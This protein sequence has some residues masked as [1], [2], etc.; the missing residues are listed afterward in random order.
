MVSSRTDAAPPRRQDAT[1]NRRRI[2]DVA[3]RLLA[4]DPHA[5]MDDL[6]AAAGL[7]RR[8]VYGHFRRRE[9]L[10]QEVAR[11]AAAGIHAILTESIAEDAT[12]PAALAAFTA[13]LW[14][15]ADE[16]R[17]LLAA[18]RLNLGPGAVQD[19]LDPVDATVRGIVAAG[20]ASGHFATDVPA[21][22]LARVLRDQAISLL[23]SINDGLWDGDA[24]AAVRLMLRTLGVPEEKLP[25]ADG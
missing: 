4:R 5:N 3:R 24:D 14:N 20:Q 10:V 17:V 11:E 16:Y 19:S 15:A 7:A 18:G 13:R 21:P 9:D 23:D 8:T 12:P 2:L 6:A 22:A 1:D 25:A